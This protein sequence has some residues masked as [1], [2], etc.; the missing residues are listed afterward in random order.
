VV[1]GGPTVRRRPV[2]EEEPVSIQTGTP[3]D[4]ELAALRAELLRLREENEADLR[5]ARRVLEDLNEDKL[6]VD[7]SMREES[8]NAEYLLEDATTIIGK[9]DAA[10]GRMDQR[11]FGTCLRCGNP[12][13][14]ARLKV[15]PYEPTCVG[16]SS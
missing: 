3:S 4:Q 9:I 5:R 15:R 10:L 7:P 1:P 14:I 16:C 6:L 13:P 11:T 12:I 8:T 2:P